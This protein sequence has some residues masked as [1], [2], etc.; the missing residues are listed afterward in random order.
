MEPIRVKYHKVITTGMA[1][2]GTPSMGAITGM[3]YIVY[4]A[5]AA[6]GITNAIVKCDGSG[7]FHECKLDDVVAIEYDV[8]VK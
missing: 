8:K 2:N 7:K 3:G 4:F 1:P 5:T 6:N